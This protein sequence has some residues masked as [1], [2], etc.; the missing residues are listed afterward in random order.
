MLKG[1]PKPVIGIEQNSM[2]LTSAREER[3][4]QPGKRLVILSNGQ[5]IGLLTPEML[6]GDALPPD[7]FAAVPKR[8]VVLGI[9]DEPA[10]SLQPAAENAPAPGPAV[11][12]RVINSWFDGVAPNK[13]LQV[14]TALRAEIQCC[15]RSVPMRCTSV[16]GIGRSLA[17]GAAIR[18]K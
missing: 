5:P 2:G 17:E 14:R 6:S 11:D 16:G 15:D 10:P 8:P 12:T 7:P 9:E 18:N 13:P 4:A 3:D 1:L